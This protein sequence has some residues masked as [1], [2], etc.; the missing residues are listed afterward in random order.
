MPEDTVD[1]DG[2]EHPTRECLTAAQDFAVA[3][4]RMLEPPHRVVRTGDGGVAFE[5][6]EDKGVRAV[7]EVQR[8]GLIDCTVFQNGQILERVSDV[9]RV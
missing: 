5:R 7:I 6:F 8:N 2:H 3:Y 9:G 4:M 1:E